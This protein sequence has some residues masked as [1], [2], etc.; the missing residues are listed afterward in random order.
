MNRILRMVPREHWILGDKIASRHVRLLDVP[1]PDALLTEM[2]REATEAAY[3]GGI[4]L[5]WRDS[6]DPDAQGFFRLEAFIPL[7]EQVFDQFFNGR[8]GYRAQYYLSPEEGILFNRDVIQG[9][10]EPLQVAYA[11]QTL[12]VDL[13]LVLTSI[14]GPHSKVWVSGNPSTFNSA[15]ENSLHPDRW[16]ENNANLGCR[17]P[18]PDSPG[19][20]F[21]GAFVHPVTRQFFVDELKLERACDL[22]SKGYS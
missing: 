20:E 5:I 11:R 18:L 19:L 13:D 10:R 7:S 14:D 21:K 22:F 16:V 9:L 6:T 1:T 3:D 8:S 17:A 4:R 12:Q 15:P 2:L